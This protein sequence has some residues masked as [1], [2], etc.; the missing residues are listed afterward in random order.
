M[1]VKAIVLIRRSDGFFDLENSKIFRNFNRFRGFR[2]KQ[3]PAVRRPDLPGWGVAVV[4][5]ES[6]V[7]LDFQ[8]KVW[9]PSVQE[10]QAIQDAMDESD[11]LTERILGRGWT[12]VRPYLMLHHF[13]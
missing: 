8:E 6:Q 2:V 5:E 12:G 4:F 3:V 10:L 9:F 7:D 13:M 11:R 1:K